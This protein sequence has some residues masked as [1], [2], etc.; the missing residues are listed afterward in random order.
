MQGTVIYSFYPMH[1]GDF[2]PSR[3]DV[4][5]GHRWPPL[6]YPVYR[7]RPQD[8]AYHATIWG[9][10]GSGKSRLLQSLFLQHLAK[11]NGICLIEPH[12][13]LSYDC[14]SSLVETGF[15]RDRDALERLVYLDWGNG[16]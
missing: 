7:L 6:A 12:H 8:Q 13:D 9:R 4:M 5:L 14:L 2:L 15:F 3:R 10:T 1:I 11:G 16:A